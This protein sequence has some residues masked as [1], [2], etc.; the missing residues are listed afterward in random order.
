MKPSNV[1]TS[2]LTYFS[3]AG[4][5]SFQVSQPRTLVTMK[6]A[7][8]WRLLFDE[9]QWVGIIISPVD[10]SLV[11]ARVT[12]SAGRD[13]DLDLDQTTQVEAFSVERDS[14][15]AE[16]SKKEIGSSAAD[17]EMP[18]LEEIVT[19]EDGKTTTDDLVVSSGPRKEVVTIKQGR[20]DLPD[21]ASHVSSVLWLRVTAHTNNGRQPA[22]DDLSS[23]LPASPR[24]PISPQRGTTAVGSPAKVVVAT[25]DS[26]SGSP[27]NR[28]PRHD[29]PGVTA[30]EDFRSLDV[31]LEFGA[32]QSR[33]FERYAL[34]DQISPHH[35]LLVSSE[36]ARLSVTVQY[37]SPHFML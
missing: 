31:K 34:I 36:I 16:D 32:A 14:H 23:L 13:L 4:V 27:D 30:S 5:Q 8:S 17:D 15:A 2:C 3:G 12:I 11:S 21:W 37:L 10:Y 29:S 26:L 24:S 28:S 22:A 35:G 19:G 20:V 7:V 33:V 1:I 18:P 25:V 9:P 6:A